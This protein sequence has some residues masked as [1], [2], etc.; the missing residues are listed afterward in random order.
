MKIE[1]LSRSCH[2]FSL[3][4]LIL[5]LIFFLALPLP[6]EAQASGSAAI[7]PP[8]TSSYPI[9]STNLVAYD[10]QGNFIHNLS[11]AQIQLFEDG[12][13]LTILRLEEQRPGASIAIVL[14]PGPPFAIQNSQGVSRYDFVV[15]ALAG[16]GMSRVGTNIDDL[17]LLTT[18]GAS[19]NHVTNPADLV[20][21]LNSGQVDARTA[22]P[23]L[24][25]LFEAEN[26][27]MDAGS[28]SSIGR[29]ILFVTPPLEGVVD[30][31]IDNIIS[32]A[33]QNN[34]RI[35]VWMVSSPGTFSSQAADQLADLAENTG[36]SYFVYT[37]EEEL[38]DPEIYFEALRS[39]YHL[40]YE[41]KLT[42]S[43][44][45][46]L[47][48]QVETNA[49]PVSTL[50][51]LFEFEILAP[52]STFISP[53]L[54]ITRGP[55]ND[56]SIS[57]M[58]EDI[59]PVLYPQEQVISTI[60]DFPD[61]RTRGLNRSALF[62]D[63]ELVVENTSPPFDK[64][65]WSIQNYNESGTHLL[66]VE[67]EDI[68]GMKG[69]SAEIPVEIRLE[70][71]APSPFSTLNK[72]IPIISALVVI[73][74][75]SIL[76][77]ALILSGRIKPKLPG[78]TIRW[79]R[80]K[81]SLVQPTANSGRP[82]QK[83]RSSWTGAQI[84]ENTIAL[85]IPI[86]EPPAD[87]RLSPIPLENEDITFGRDPNLADIF[88]DDPALEAVHARLV[89]DSKGNFQLIDEGTV[90]GTWINYTPVSKEGSR[91]ENGD[92]IHIGRIGFRFELN[93]PDQNLVPHI[94]KRPDR[95]NSGIYSSNRD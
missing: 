71:P 60:I 7:T 18:G 13:P 86:S 38:P 90:A 79:R 55:L 6:V 4:L 74:G 43:G 34:I 26:L 23:G 92:W 16:W 94:E 68:F 29:A 53:P 28:R 67:V 52:M 49:E 95:L 5:L 58:D 17:S 65:I 76:F 12:E 50:P 93:R 2:Y 31:T 40:E 91:L 82:S 61:R 41:S 78:K 19:T 10:S 75:G 46:Q 42:T 36:G 72:N 69:Q 20:T 14:N 45:H 64:F 73:L 24:D 57:F 48:A 51:Q 89:S 30:D 44:T 37:G 77:L 63:G 22:V 39:N 66:Q 27:V 59:P 9:F 47:Q 84:S 81:D 85:L 11:S 8:S 21:V 87:A 25:T 83:R 80:E 88:F 33:Q 62:V 32:Q 15:D 35:N 3:K 70:L 1:T 54:V 56:E